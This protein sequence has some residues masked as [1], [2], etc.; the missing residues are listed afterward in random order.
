[1]KLYVSSSR[2]C[3]LGLDSSK[4]IAPD[5]TYTLVRPLAD[6]Y[7][8]LQRAGNMSIVFCLLLN[9]VHFLHDE[10][11]LTAGLS[12]TR[13]ALCEILAIRCLRE[14]GENMLDLVAV[15]TTAWPVYSGAGSDVIAKAQEYNDDLDDRV[16]N[17]IEMAII[18]KS[19]RFLK[20]TPS[21]RVIDAIWRC[22]LSSRFMPWGL[23]NL[24]SVVSAY[25]KPLATMH[26]WRT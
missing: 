12:K 5:L 14:Y 10:G 9:R 16:G 19:K 3:M 15:A 21:Q 18:S 8:Q 6:K 23:Y 20:S 22:V 13:A 7:T 26:S 17:A 24:R 25:I 4:L 11:V 1:M 2:A